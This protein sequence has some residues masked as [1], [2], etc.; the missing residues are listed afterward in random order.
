M[1]FG[2]IPKKKIRESQKDYIVRA[3]RTLRSQGYSIK[4]ISSLIR[5][6]EIVVHNALIDDPKK[7]LLTNEEREEILKLVADGISIAE[8]AEKFNKSKY[9]INE[10]IKNPIKNTEK[11]T[12]NVKEFSKKDLDQMKKWYTSGKTISW[13]ARQFDVPAINIKKRLIAC[14]I[15]DP[16][17]SFKLEDKLNNIERK[18]ILDM[19]NNGDSINQM[20]K[21]IGRTQ[22]TIRKYLVKK[23]LIAINDN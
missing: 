3:S 19:F 4:E 6:D 1:V 13:I 16:N 9:R 20:V 22:T 21:Q 23:G 10:V 14:E 12:M 18:K 8:I 11:D 2:G 7:H 15:Y 5:A 17:N